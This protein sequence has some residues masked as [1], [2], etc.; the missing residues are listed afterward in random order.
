MDV[1]KSL[2]RR[3][4]ITHETVCAA[5]VAQKHALILLFGV[6]PPFLP[7]IHLLR[8]KVLPPDPTTPMVC[9][10]LFRSAQFVHMSTEFD[11]V[12]HTYHHSWYSMAVHSVAEPPPT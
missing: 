6:P 8:L 7:G 1:K 12:R 5:V 3:P 4:S 9:G 11:R 2:P 10:M